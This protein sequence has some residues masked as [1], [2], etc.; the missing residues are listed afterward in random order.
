MQL[1]SRADAAAKRRRSK[2]DISWVSSMRRLQHQPNHEPA[3]A[4]ASQ[5]ASTPA[6]APHIGL[7][8]ASLPGRLPETPDT[9]SPSPALPRSM[10]GR[11]PLQRGRA[12][13]VF[14]VSAVSQTLVQTLNPE[15]RPNARPD[16]SLA[17][18]RSMA[19]PRLQRLPGD[20]ATF[21]HARAAQNAQTAQC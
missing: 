7:G 11:A 15:P 1:R 10:A 6:S 3:G 14:L 20:L 12:S 9:G 8:R 16:P 17:L 13:S 19:R 21:I 18:P 5:P 2:T 4:A